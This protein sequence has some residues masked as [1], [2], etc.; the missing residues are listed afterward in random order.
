MTSVSQDECK[1]TH[2]ANKEEED[3]EAPAECCDTDHVTVADS[4]HGDHE[5]VDA[6]PVGEALA[7]VEVGR[8]ARVLQLKYH[9][10]LMLHGAIASQA[11][12]TMF[13]SCNIAVSCGP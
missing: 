12:V 10:K 3:L 6:V 4:G 5:E 11:S 2:Q 7:V 1:V 9:H 8:V 13:S